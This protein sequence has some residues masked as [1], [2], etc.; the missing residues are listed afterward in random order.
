M[1]S[2]SNVISLTFAQLSVKGNCQQVIQVENKEEKI[3][4]SVG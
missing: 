4:F 2:G 3:Y 1:A